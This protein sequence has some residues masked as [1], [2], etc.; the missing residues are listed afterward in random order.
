MIWHLPSHFYDDEKGTRDRDKYED[1]I[2]LPPKSCG[3]PIAWWQAH[4]NEYPRLSTMILD[5]FAVF[6]MFAECER[7]FLVA[8]T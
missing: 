6:M 4:R 8:K 7:V 5:L 1:Y 3:A 2:K